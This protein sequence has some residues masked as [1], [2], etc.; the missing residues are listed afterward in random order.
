MENQ[1]FRG[2]NFMLKEKLLP[3]SIFALAFAIIISAFI[4]SKGMETNGSYIGSG[5]ISVE[6]GLDSISNSLNYFYNGSAEDKFN[7]SQ[8]A[9]YLGI[10]QSQL[11]ELATLDDSG[12]PHVK[13]DGIYI[14]NRNAIDNWLQTAKI[15]IN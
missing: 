14:F 10:S 9:D 6:H 4:I 15:E 11:L 8:A 1:N 7:L 3:I 5:L 12:I 13:I 2:N